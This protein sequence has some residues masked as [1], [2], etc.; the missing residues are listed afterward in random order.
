MTTLPMWKRGTYI[1]YDLPKGRCLHLTYPYCC[2]RDLTSGARRRTARGVETT[3][4]LPQKR[5]AR[6]FRESCLL[7][8]I[9]NS[10]D[11][12]QCTQSTMSMVED[13]ISND[14]K[15]GDNPP[16]DSSEFQNPIG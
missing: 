1:V 10:Q 9:H 11:N 13:S 15:T 8:E 2:K 6:L 14:T 12:F 5:N 16:F 4:S 3:I 7:G